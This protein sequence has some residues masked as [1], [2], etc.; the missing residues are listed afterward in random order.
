[1][2]ENMQERIFE[3]HAIQLDNIEI[4]QLCFKA[5]PKV[6]GE[7]QPLPELI[8]L[9]G[10]SKYDPVAK[11]ILV[12]MMLRPKDSN[13]SFL[14]VELVGIFTVDEEKFDVKLLDNWAEKNAP[15]ILLPYLRE[16]AYALSVRAGIDPIILPLTEVPTSGKE[17]TLVQ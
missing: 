13:N 12:G 6:D 9:V 16:N 17:K 7:K 8:T 1:M 10:K 11:R 3:K 14:I 5:E 15:F 2:I 4:R